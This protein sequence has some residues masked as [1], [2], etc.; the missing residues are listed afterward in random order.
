MKTPWGISRCSPI[1]PFE[2]SKGM[3]LVELLVCL[4]IVAL[5]GSLLTYS[6]RKAIE[7]A[8]GSR[9]LSE[10]RQI[11]AALSLYAIDNDQQYPPVAP[12]GD[13]P[14]MRTPLVPYLPF[15][16]RFNSAQIATNEHPI[17]SAP[18]ARVR[19]GDRNVRRAY[20]GGGALYITSGNSPTSNAGSASA[21][22]RGRLL[23]TII[24]PGNGVLFF[25]AVVGSNGLCRDGTAW[26]RFSE[27]IKRIEAGVNQSQY[28]DFRYN[29]KAQIMFAD[30][31]IESLA[32]QQLANRFVESR[33]YEGLK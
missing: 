29:G 30:Y 5:L 13:R 21:P 19:E 15:N 18:G 4:A 12:T 16:A 3:T 10:K 28:V 6:I 8:H 17:F 31:H 2:K 11:A 20:S 27:D 14:W 1:A 26:V 23:S 24:N 9:S 33:T 7:H 32:P 22:E 25:D